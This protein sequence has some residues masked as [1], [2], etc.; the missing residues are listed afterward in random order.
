VT[1]SYVIEMALDDRVL[2]WEGDTEFSSDLENFHYR[3]T[4]RVS[5]N[6]ALLREKTWSETI[7]RDF[8]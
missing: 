4:R 8:Q 7:P 1:S 6:G 5:E 3:Y 2:L